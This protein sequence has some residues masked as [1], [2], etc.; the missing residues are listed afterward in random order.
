MRKAEIIFRKS[1]RKLGFRP[2]LEYFEGKKFEN[3]YEQ[4]MGKKKIFFMITPEYGNNGDQAICYATL[5]YLKDNFSDYEVI[6]IPLKDTYKYMRA[7]KHAYEKNDIILLQ[8]G[9]NMGNLYI[10]IERY[11]RFIMK[12]L[13][14]CKI[15]SMPTTI[16]FT[17]D[18]KGRRELAK[19]IKAYNRC[20]DLTLVVREEPSLE[21]AK[22]HF[23]CKT[24][25]NP[26]M[27]LYLLGKYD[28]K[29]ERK[30][31]VFCLRHDGESTNKN[32]YIFISEMFAKDPTCRIFDTAI[33]RDVYAKTRE[34]EITASF[35]ELSQAGCV[36]TDRLHCMVFCAITK[37]PCVVTTALDA[38]IKGTYEWIKDL[39]YIRMVDR[40][41]EKLVEKAMEE[42]KAADRSINVDLDEK[43][44]K[45]L[46]DRIM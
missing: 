32:S 5:R 35:N 39:S 13:S 34:A 27:V 18:S 12:H 38:K 33:A 44:F 21:F 45:T 6:Q 24:V 43:Y 16:T 41:D 23:N 7:V 11:R 1:C 31:T 28:I 3:C 19:S 46:R 15:I 22:K 9:G 2:V 42:A 20:K 30:D 36:V 17:K 40:L 4:Y 29:N 10:Y 14:D 37:T 26:D 25:L 8:G